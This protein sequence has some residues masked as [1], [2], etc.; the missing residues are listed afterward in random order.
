MKTETGSSWTPAADQPGKT[1]RS[2]GPARKTK[3]NRHFLQK[4]LSIYQG[5]EEDTKTPEPGKILPMRSLPADQNRHES[6]AENDTEK[7]IAAE[8][9][10]ATKKRIPPDEIGK[11][12]Q[13]GRYTNDSILLCYLDMIFVEN[14]RQIVEKPSVYATFLMFLL[15]AL[16]YT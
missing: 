6:T 12:K 2:G 4:S 15:Y 14:C 5:R 16:L 10:T 7:R 3:E 1:A 11:G 8:T 9:E 13:Y